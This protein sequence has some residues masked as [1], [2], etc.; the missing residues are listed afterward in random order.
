MLLQMFA[1]SRIFKYMGVRAALFILPGI[2]LAGYS[3]ILFLPLLPVIRWT[4]IFENGTDYSIQNTT[5][6]ALF[7]STS[8]EA[9]YKAKAAI[10][11]FFVR[12]GDVA[13][14]G[15]VMAGT[16]AGLGIKGFASVNLVLTLVWL[17][18]A[19]GILREHRRRARQIDLSATVHSP[20]VAATTVA[21][22]AGA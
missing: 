3:F 16:A 20:V 11:T 9:K 4:K 19:A 22:P 15:I 2:A 7:L 10:D 17:A 5:R 6:Q 18:L 8:R 13:Q 14:A 12:A 1:V 21:R